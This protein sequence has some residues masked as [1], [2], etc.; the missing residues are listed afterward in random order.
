MIFHADQIAELND[1]AEQFSEA[2]F[3][4]FPNYPK[5][6][7][8]PKGEAGRIEPEKRGRK[9]RVTKVSSVADIDYEEGEAEDPELT[10]EDF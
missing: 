4:K 9:A 1:L 6:R 8:P 2:M 10:E 5:S 3:H 7:T